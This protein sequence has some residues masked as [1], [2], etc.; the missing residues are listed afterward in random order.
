M[1]QKE[2]REM[3]SRVSENQRKQHWVK[4]ENWVKKITD[5]KVVKKASQGYCSI[6]VKVPKKFS[7]TAVLDSFQNLGYETKAIK[8]TNKIYIRW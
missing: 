4:Y 6:E 5:T 1:L 2:A 3:T 8:G 7:K